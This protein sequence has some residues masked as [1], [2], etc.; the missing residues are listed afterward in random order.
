MQ[1]EHSALARGG[2]SPQHIGK[3]M[4]GATILVYK[5]SLRS[6]F[7]LQVFVVVPN[8]HC[9]FVYGKPAREILTIPEGV[10]LLPPTKLNL[11]E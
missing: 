11:H 5:D 9:S 1:C 3:A 6:N 10:F 8:K 4:K 7:V 2:R